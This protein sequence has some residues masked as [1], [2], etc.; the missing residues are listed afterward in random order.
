MTAED[1]DRVRIFYSSRNNPRIIDRYDD[2]ITY[3]HEAG[4]DAE[5]VDIDDDPRPAQEAGIVT[6]PTVVI[7]RGEEQETHIGVTVGMADILKDDPY[8]RSVL[9]QTG[10]EA[11]RD[12][13]DEELEAD[14][15]E[16]RVAEVLSAFFAADGVSA[17][18]TGFDADEPVA[19]VQISPDESL[20]GSGS[21]NVV[22]E[23]FEAFLGGFFTEVF[24]T[25]VNAG[26]H[27][28]VRKG[29]EVCRFRI[30]TTADEE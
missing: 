26:E 5:V 2:A 24:G 28:C 21:R 10:F 20:E 22:H 18:L 17:E 8:G 25:A 29:D 1:I 23:Q 6:T 27:E 19:E 14:A 15:D 3:L 13:V 16:P 9:Y 12:L 30:A 7:D 4:I 11:G